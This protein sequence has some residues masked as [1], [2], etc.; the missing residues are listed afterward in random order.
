MIAILSDIHGNL[1]ALQA[2]LADIGRRTIKD[3]YNLGDTVGYGPNP[4][5]CVD[6]AMEMAVV[7][8]GNHDLALLH[9]PEGFPTGAA[10]SLYW[11]RRL[12]E[13]ADQESPSPNRRFQFMQSLPH[14]RDDGRVCYVHGSP[15]RPLHEYV[16]PEDVCNQKKMSRLSSHFD[17]L[18]FNGHTHIPGIFVQSSTDWRFIPADERAQGFPLDDHKMICN[19]GSVGQPRDGDWRACYVL[20][21]G[22]RVW[23]RR[24]EYDI[25]TTIQKINSN[26]DLEWGD[27][28]HDGR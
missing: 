17:G 23:F 4:V 14:R 5:E 1:E 18:C 13:S 15:R 11:S 7:L 6:L 19:V 26:P 16:F 2:V 24:V 9:D 28:L 3:V 22:N 27:R 12:I 20:F 21:D 25:E 10:K 8:L